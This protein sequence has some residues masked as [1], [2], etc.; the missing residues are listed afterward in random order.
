MDKSVFKKRVLITGCILSVILFFF[1]LKL[2]NLHFSERIILP[3]KEPV[4]NGRGYIFDREGYLLALSIEFDSVYVNPQELKDPSAAASILAPVVNTPSSELLSKFSGNKKFIWLIRRCD[5]QLSAK[6][7]SMKIKGL[8]F[9][10]EYKRVYP[11][12]T[13]AANVIGFVGLDNSGLDGIEYRYNKVLSGKDEV[14]K[15]EISREIYQKKN[16]TLTIDRYIQHVAEDELSKAM[17]LHRAA[18]GSVV[19]LEVDTGR[20]LSFAKYPSFDPNNFGSYNSAVRSNFSFVDSFEPGS[21]MKIITLAALLENKPDSVNKEYFCEGFVDINDVRINCLHNHGKV[22]MDQIIS[23]SCNAGMIQSVK[24]LEKKDLYKTLRKF[25]LG[26]PTGLELPGEAE[27]IVR[28]VAQWSG[29]SKY[30]I[31]IGHEIS[32]T[33]IQLAAAFNAIANGGVYVTPSL[34]EKIEKPDGTLV[35]GFY[36]RTKGRIIKQEDAS[37]LMKK[38]RD[39][40]ASGTGKRADSIYYQIAGKT[41][42]SQKFSSAAG[43]YSDRN[44][45]SFVGIAPYQNP[46]ICML[47]VI[48]DPEDRF[49]GG[50]SAA[51]VLMKITDRIL[52]YFGI[53]GKDVSSLRVKRSQLVNKFEFQTIPDL[54]GMNT[55]EAAEVLRVLGEKYGVKYYIK[56]SGRVYGQKPVPGNGIKQGE[57]IILFMR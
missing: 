22:N 57:S 18:Q 53:G 31:A 24:S 17:L 39:V 51:P 6:I 19:I 55:S 56:G 42:T 34:I 15:D 44:V 52:P 4:E 5:D 12:N 11:Y 3:G 16:L 46:K 40:V 36:P 38:M 45:S 21:T 32:V 28:P 43:G 1:V 49:T 54:R 35:Q 13:L 25:G 26:V 30:S 9:T 14:V 23:Q 29:L 47:V 48:D 33:S 41:G 8:Y 2:F 20:V 50:A 7:K 10:K 27:G 37:I